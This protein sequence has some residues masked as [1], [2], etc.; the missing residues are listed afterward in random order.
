M[1]Y[2]WHEDVERTVQNETAQ[3]AP[4]KSESGAPENRVRKEG[5][6]FW[7]F[8]T[9]RRDRATEE[10]TADRVLERV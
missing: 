4:R 2:S 1:C 8:R 5:P 9:G 7:V 3:E 6:R 10:A